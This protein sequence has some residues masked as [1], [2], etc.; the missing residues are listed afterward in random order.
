[1]IGGQTINGL[2]ENRCSTASQYL[3]SYLYEYYQKD[4]RRDRFF[5]SNNLAM[6]AEKFR[7]IKG[8]NADFPLAAAEDRELGSRWR[9]HGFKMMYVSAAIVNHSHALTFGKFCHQHF[10]YGQGAHHYHR[11][12]SDRHQGLVKPEPLVFYL[13]LLRYPF[14]KSTP[15]SALVLTLLLFISQ[16]ANTLGF[17]FAKGIRKRRGSSPNNTYSPPIA[18]EKKK[19]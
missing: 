10:N 15:G 11:I 3:I 1:M 19:K 14:L 9:N 7:F 6:S 17:F 2:K 12:R 5:T 8:F 18:L 13:N 4:A 16:V